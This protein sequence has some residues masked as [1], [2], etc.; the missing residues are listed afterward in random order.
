MEGGKAEAT[1]SRPLQELSGR[2]R[3][4]ENQGF[5]IAGIPAALQTVAGENSI[6]SAGNVALVQ[7]EKGNRGAEQQHAQENR[8]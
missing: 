2:I 8:A 6:T 7:T 4:S 5:R 1:I 3:R